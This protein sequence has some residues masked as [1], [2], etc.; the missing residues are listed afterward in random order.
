MIPCRRRKLN[1]T[2]FSSDAVR[3]TRALRSARS[4]NPHVAARGLCGGL[5]DLGFDISCDSN[6]RRIVSAAA[7]G[8]NSPF[9]LWSDRISDLVV[10]N[11]GQ[12][13]VG[14]VAEHDRN[15]VPSVWRW[16]TAASAWR[17]SECPSGVAALLVATVSLVDGA[18]RLAE[19]ERH[20]AGAARDCRACVLGFAGLALLVGP[21]ELGGSG[22]IDPIGVAILGVGS[23]AWA[24]GSI[25]AKH[26]QMPSS[27]LL[28]SAMQSLTGGADFV[29]RRRA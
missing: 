14:R 28:G 18:H 11:E 24:C 19:A 22:R 5:S 4:S 29:D 3:R 8:R 9:D 2:T 26:G 10:E 17:K 25:Y 21:K 13:D 7:R 15:R 12:A 16:G 6:R 27:P 20:A 23:F 1:L